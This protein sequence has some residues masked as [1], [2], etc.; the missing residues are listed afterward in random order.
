MAEV[1]TCQAAL[2]VPT[3]TD[4]TEWCHYM[5]H[6]V[7]CIAHDNGKIICR[8]A[9]ELVCGRERARI[10]EAAGHRAVSEPD[11]P[12]TRGVMLLSV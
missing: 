7:D 3:G 10:P 11:G 12:A 4:K 5:Q 1:P 6:Y 8:L 9:T 2:I